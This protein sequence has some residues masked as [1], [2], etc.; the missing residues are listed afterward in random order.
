ML[1]MFLLLLEQLLSYHETLQAYSSVYYVG[2]IV[3]VAIIFFG[4]VVKPPRNAIK[5]KKVQ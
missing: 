1:N 3:P 2:T 5:S 4:L